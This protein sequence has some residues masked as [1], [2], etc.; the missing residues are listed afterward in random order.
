M[1]LKSHLFDRVRVKP[2]S[3]GV[4]PPGQTRCQFP[5]C[6]Q[7]GEFR[8]PVGRVREGQYF[9]FCLNHV[10]EYNVT[11]DYFRGMSAEAIARFQRDAMV[12]HRPTWTMG[13]Y[14]GDGVLCDARDVWCRAENMPG[15]RPMNFHRCSRE[16]PK[17]RYGVAALKALNQL[18][19]DDSVDMVAIKA[20]YKDL[21]KR[22]HPDANAGDRSNEDKLREIIRAY[23]YLKSTKHV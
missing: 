16:R 15:M 20:R 21:V 4:R 3:E 11:Y 1:N 17:P 14:S 23:T 18:G 8:A 12:G 10:R 13:V 6:T 9:C 19:L 2:Q 7:A 22:L 5:G